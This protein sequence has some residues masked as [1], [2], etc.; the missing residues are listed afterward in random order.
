MFGTRAKA[1]GPWYLL[2]ALAAI[3]IAAVV[4]HRALRNRRL[5]AVL[6][7][8]LLGYAFQQGLAWSEGRGLAGMRDRI[9]T[10]GHAEFATI[11]VQQ[12]SVWDVMAGYEAKLQ[13]G[14]RGR[15][16]H[17]KPPGQL[18]FYMLTERVARLF[19]RDQSPEARLEATRTLAAI[20]WPLMA[21]AVLV[22]LFLALR[23]ITGDES[24]FLACMLYLLVPSV[25][26]ITLHTDEVLFPLLFMLPIWMLVEAQI[27]GR[28]GW[29]VAAGTT[30]YVGAF[31]TFPMLFA[32]PLAAACAAAIAFAQPSAE[33][34]RRALKRLV[35][36]GLVAAASFAIV[37]M[38]VRIALGYDFFA[39][40]SGAV[41]A[42][43]AWKGPVSGWFSK[44]Y[45]AGLNALEFAL[46]L[47]VPIAVL[48]TSAIR[49]SLIAAADGNLVGMTLPAIAIAGV[50]VYLAFW[51]GAKAETARLW[52]FT[53]P[54][55]CAL[56]AEGLRRF[57][58]GDRVVAITFALALQW[59]TVLLTKTG[60]DFF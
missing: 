54:I 46:W 33:E 9:V 18:L 53:V 45:F 28:R 21:Y 25:A 35:T 5:E 49:R 12:A 59:L 22:P 40:L 56:A 29:A 43:E 32:A 4:L 19:A 20:V 11:A 48:L 38:L 7:L 36:S 42:N 57:A 31:F 50:F 15:Y 37:F 30:L 10:T 24:A 51:G 47:G 23:R 60:Q 34:R 1:A 13:R 17:T 27:T 58:D 14:E 55:G 44:F 26:L 6:A 3:P 2:V 52:M 41:Q 39:R 16:A 8:V